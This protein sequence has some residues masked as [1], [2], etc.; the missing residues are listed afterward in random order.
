MAGCSNEMHKI[1]FKILNTLEVQIKVR[2]LVSIMVFGLVSVAALADTVDPVLYEWVESN[3]F[4][5][6]IGP[7]TGSILVQPLGV[8][9]TATDFTDSLILDFNF[10]FD[11]G[12][13]FTL[14]DLFQVNI[15]FAVGGE[16]RELILS[17][18]LIAPL[19][20]DFVGLIV[21]F[22]GGSADYKIQ[23]ADGLDDPGTESHGGSWLIA[24][25]TPVPE[26]GTLTLLAAG[27]LAGAAFR[28]RFK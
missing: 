16:L 22:A 18:P 5:G 24:D 3:V 20:G 8:G 13:T 11:N 7:G 14:A 19:P 4:P 15:P 17:D 12:V 1:P 6:S 25:S 9:A 21:I 27:L 26:P 10:T 28:K 2:F 23:R